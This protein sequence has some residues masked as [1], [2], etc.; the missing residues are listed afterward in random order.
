MSTRLSWGRVY[1]E[2]KRAHLGRHLKDNVREGVHVFERVG[3]KCKG[4]RGRKKERPV[5]L[6]GRESGGRGR[7]AQDYL[8]VSSSTG[9]E[10]KGL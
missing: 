4:E 5:V 3:G 1:P 2:W 8:A 9:G 10:K 7:E 6:V